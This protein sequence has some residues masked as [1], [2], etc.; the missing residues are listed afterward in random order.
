M[1]CP[2]HCEYGLLLS[3]NITSKCVICVTLERRWL[4]DCIY[5]ILLG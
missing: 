5:D 3:D 2:S 1:S 4:P